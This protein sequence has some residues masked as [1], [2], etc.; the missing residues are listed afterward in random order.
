MPALFISHSSHD[1][2]IA[3]EITASLKQLGYEEVFLDFD[4]ETGIGAGADW[5]KTLYEKL[6]RCHALILILTPSWL[7]STWCRI[8]LA[9]AR[10]LG[11]VI[12]PIICQ[13]LGQRYVLPEIQA[14]DVIDWKSD[15]LD[16]VEMR[17]RSI[18]SEL[19][20]GFKF[21]PHRPPYPGIH[22]FEAEDAA[23]YFGRDDESR[24]VIER[25]DARRT[26]GG[27]RVFVIIGASGSGKSSLLK[28]GVLP[29]LDRRRREWIV[30]PAIRPEKT[31][32]EMLAKSIAEH[33]GDAQGWRQYFEHLQ[34]PD[35]IEYLRQ[36]INDLRIGDAKNA[37][38]LL[39]IDQFEEVFTVTPAAESKLVVDLL[40]RALAADTGLP[41]MVLATGRSDVLEGLIEAGDL[42][43]FTESYPLPLMPLNRVPR[44]VEG[45]AAVAG[46]V[47]DK[48]L[49][50]RIEQDVESPEA[51]PL[52]AHTLWL[53]H[54]RGAAT[55]RLS[56]TEY[57]ALR[58][59]DGKFNPIQNSVRLVA[60][61]AI[62]GPDPSEQSIAALRDAFVPHLV[63][64]RLD[65]GK[66]LRQPSPLSEIPVSSHALIQTL[67]EAR[68]LT[69]RAAEPE[70][71]AKGDEA[72][73]GDDKIIEVAHEAL[74]KAWPIL[75]QLLTEEHAFLIDLE[76]IRT[77]YEVWRQA[78][79]DQKDAALLQGLLLARARDWLMKYPRR[80]VGR[81]MEPVRA[82]IALSAQA[83]DAARKR[84]EEAAAKVRE[85]ERRL[86]QGAI[87]AAIIFFI[88]AAVAGWQYFQA[89]SA[90]AT[91]SNERAI[92]VAHEIYATSQAVADVNG[93]CSVDLAVAAYDAAKLTA[94]MDLL[95]FETAVRDALGRSRVAATI[96]V[97][98]QLNE[99][100]SWRSDGS[101]LSFVDGDGKLWLWTQGANA[102]HLLNDK[103]SAFSAEWLPGGTQ[104]VVLDTNG[105]ETWD[106]ATGTLLKSAPLQAGNW[107]R[108]RLDHAGEQG[109]AWSRTGGTALL[110][111]ATGKLQVLAPPTGVFRS[112]AW[113]PDGKQVALG[114][115]GGDT[116]WVV[117]LAEQKFFRMKNPETI[118]SI[119]WSPDGSVIA[120][121]LD[122]GR[123]W[124]WDPTNGDHVNTLDGHSNQVFGL[125]FSP[126]GKM[127]V[128]ASWDQSLRIWDTQTWRSLQRLTGHTAGI[129]TVR[130]SPVSTQIATT[131]ADKT[132][133]LWFAE[134]SQ[135]PQTW[136]DTPGWVWN[137]GWN[138]GGT[139]LAATAD[140]EVVVRDKDGKVSRIASPTGRFAGGGWNA[141][142]SAYAFVDDKRVVVVNGATWAV[143]MD[144][145]FD[146]QQPL[147]VALAPDDAGLVAVVSRSGVTVFAV[148]SGEERYTLPMITPALAFS[149]DRKR[150]ALGPCNKDTI[151]LAEA[152]TRKPTASLA[153]LDPDKATW[154]LAWSQD[155][156]WLA[157]ASDDA[158]A[159][160][161]QLA[162][163][164]T[165][166][167]L[168]GHI[169]DVKGVAWNKAGDRIATA[170]L[171]QSVRIWQMPSGRLLTVLN[172][173]ASGVRGVAWSSD[174]KMLA[175]ASEDGT[176][177]LFLTNFDQVLALARAQ[178]KI[179]LT[180]AEYQACKSRIA[181][182]TPTSK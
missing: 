158:T 39:P 66:R 38:V 111:I 142:H 113:S 104:L 163:P 155:G 61:Q 62:G 53:L 63:R 128:S 101:E 14:V 46:L 84:A 146:L 7:A 97:N 178:Q 112:Y 108:L 51:L 70:D 30:L 72:K 81:D 26:Q 78:P 95:P 174:E 169:A 103:I 162:S 149:T 173:H 124:L 160:I 122:S 20:R 73:A 2:A 148:P 134:T 102:P 176:A 69:T 31:P 59:P 106:A 115:D 36:L 86:F 151:V 96:P 60:D 40:T 80:F 157:A 125:D 27:A 24:A 10:A 74:F 161:W 153:G 28:A 147:A 29:Q 11:K 82:F 141:S 9:Q 181:Q 117:Q 6:S 58:S 76:R 140:T 129:S 172:G 156:R 32:L 13:P 75:D 52:L 85:T 43:Q 47:V 114:A 33:R 41:M 12:L 121:G 180:A 164:A 154:G 3:A 143:I 159:H 91:A 182:D 44:L 90:R 123:I 18:T 133:R 126:D 116:V 110:D 167:L 4:K 34:K 93:E 179:G 130:W 5:E 127:L 100:V 19:A 35:V 109:L 144:H 50:A 89:E 138:A 23:I 1:G 16:R 49:P 25:L 136:L 98:A 21:D 77:V 120:V 45:P 145:P 17:L 99:P 139:A 22:A 105:V 152:A 65:D 55:K 56:L 94:G 118:A 131:S 37:T 88:A 132:A 135:S 119:A 175:T 68:L 177:R 42:A 171:D 92:A 15:G 83:E 64:V 165:P 48:G 71:E 57:E 87:V 8:E 150:L 137:T 107:S 166:I 67:T 54:Q 168:R 170:S 79:Q